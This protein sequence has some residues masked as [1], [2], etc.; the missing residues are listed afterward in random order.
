M[1]SFSLKVSSLS[2]SDREPSEDRVGLMII[3][4]CE[5]SNPPGER[6]WLIDSL[7]VN[8]KLHNELRAQ[9]MNHPWVA[10][11]KELLYEHS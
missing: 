9:N 5:P 7:I 3:V 6:I 2:T 10:E 4:N 11:C 8:V 1:W